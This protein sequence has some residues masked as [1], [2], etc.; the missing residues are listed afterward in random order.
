[1][2]AAMLLFQW[3]EIRLK[4]KDIDTA[5]VEVE[6]LGIT[7]KLIPRVLRELVLEVEMEV[8]QE[9]QEAMRQKT[10]APVVEEAVVLRIPLLQMEVKGL[11]EW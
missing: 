11:M 10:Q 7:R 1:M 6:E 9:A 4:K 3:L 8:A 5:P 2:M